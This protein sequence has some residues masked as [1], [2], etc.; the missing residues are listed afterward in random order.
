MT[1]EKPQE[2]TY[3][4]RSSKMDEEKLNND[5]MWKELQLRVRT[6]VIQLWRKL[7]CHEEL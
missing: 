4:S 1:K 3:F 5:E 7:I 2:M 6:G